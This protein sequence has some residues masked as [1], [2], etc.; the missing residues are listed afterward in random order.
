MEEKRMRILEKLK[1]LSDEEFLLLVQQV[2][3]LF[4]PV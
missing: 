4:K 1:N 3:D 2:E